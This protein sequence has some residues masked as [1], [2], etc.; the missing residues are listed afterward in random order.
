[1][2]HVVHGDGV[3]GPGGQ[4]VP[5]HGDEVRLGLD[6][7]LAANVYQGVQVHVGVVAVDDDLG[8]VARH[9]VRLGEVRARR[10]HEDLLALLQVPPSVEVEGDLRVGAGIISVD[11]TRPDEE[12]LGLQPELAALHTLAEGQVLAEH[13]VQQHRREHEEGERHGEESVRTGASVPVVD[14]LLVRYEGRPG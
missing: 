14:H 6:Q 1:M 8:G 10:V 5:V 2:G 12:V 7:V 9:E 3:A 4:S 11:Q 13:L